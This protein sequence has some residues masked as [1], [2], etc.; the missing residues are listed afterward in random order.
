[1]E[2]YGFFYFF[3][4]VLIFILFLYRG[5][6]E[7]YNLDFLINFIIIVYLGGYLGCRLFYILLHLDKV[8]LLDI[9]SSRKVG[10]VFYGGYIVG[11]ILGIFYIF[12]TKNNVLKVLDIATPL[13]GL[14][15]F[16]GRIGCFLHG[17]CFGISCNIN[18]ICLRF[19]KDSDVFN[20]QLQKGMISSSDSS[21]LAVFPVQLF[22]S[23]LNGL[24]FLFF[25]SKYK[26]RKE[27]GMI[28]FG[29][30]LSH[31]LVRF[32]LDFLRAEESKLYGLT[33]SQYIAGFIILLILVIRTSFKFK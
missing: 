33:I 23:I 16:I 5:R 22:E 15:L 1:M 27:D 4:L 25:W 20:Y 24:I 11:L 18:F 3:A 8:S 9:F 7:G 30:L 28:T 31:S 6:K 14:G 21:T 17:C 2:S 29:V 19:P 12:L 13:L 26:N 10:Y 32:F